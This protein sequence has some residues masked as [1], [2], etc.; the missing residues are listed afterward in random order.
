MKPARIRPVQPQLVVAL[1]VDTFEQAAGLIDRLHAQAGMFKVG[2]QLF[3]G[4]G[5]QIITHAQ[6]LGA[7]VFLDLKYHDIPHTVGRAVAQAARLGVAMLTV[8]VAGGEEMLRA[9]VAARG[10]AGLRLVGVTVLT[11]QDAGAQEVLLRAE[12][13]LACGLDGVVASAQEAAL[14]RQRL[15]DEF[16]LVTP[17]IRPAGSDA[18]DQKRVATVQD[19]VQAGSDYLVVGRPIVAAVDPA[20][21]AK[22]IVRQIAGA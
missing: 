6:R 14:L 11:S 5:P 4:C 18:G 17:G 12:N 13:A 2:S 15:G 3:T 10:A 19:A 20:A 22:E 7:S 8:H 16:I 1:D 9:A 21:A